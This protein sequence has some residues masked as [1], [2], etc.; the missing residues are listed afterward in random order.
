[1]RS[2]II[3]KIEA[4]IIRPFLFTVLQTQKPEQDVKTRL[5]PKMLN[6][7]QGENRI[8]TKGIITQRRSGA[9]QHMTKTSIILKMPKNRIY[10]IACVYI[11][12][13]NF[14]Q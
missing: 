8:V 13:F 12:Q 4:M 6:E 3:S 11:Q 10:L 2:N 1:M 5:R 7:T 14:V 9:S